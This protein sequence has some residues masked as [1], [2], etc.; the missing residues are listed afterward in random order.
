MPM[1]AW[2]NYITIQKFE[3]RYN[4][5]LLTNDWKYDDAVSNIMPKQQESST[6][7]LTRGHNFK[8]FWQR[9]EN[10]YNKTS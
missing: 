10:Q 3:R 8:I 4:R 9:A 5:N 7:L 2:L 1:K 6:S